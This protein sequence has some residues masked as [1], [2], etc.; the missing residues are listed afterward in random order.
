M[1]MKICPECNGDGYE[2]YEYVTG[3]ID[4]KSLAPWQEWRERREVCTA[5]RGTGGE[6][7]KD[8]DTFKQSLLQFLSPPTSSVH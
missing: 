4:D 2:I 8:F 7:P 1:T 5:C 3:G 6:A